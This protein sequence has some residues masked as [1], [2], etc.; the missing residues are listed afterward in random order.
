MYSVSLMLERHDIVDIEGNVNVNCCALFCVFH[1]G[2]P[3]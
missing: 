2:V 1:M 3:T